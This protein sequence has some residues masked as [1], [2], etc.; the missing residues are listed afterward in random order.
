MVKYL[1]EP[2]LAREV[3]DNFLRLAQKSRGLRFSVKRN[4]KEFIVIPKGVTIC[5]GAYC[6]ILDAFSPLLENVKGVIFDV[7]GLHE[8]FATLIEV[9]EEGSV[10]VSPSRP[11]ELVIELLRGLATSA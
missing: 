3:I 11:K 10:V 8:K 7:L 9:Y 1:I 5:E 4:N 2:R 6:Y